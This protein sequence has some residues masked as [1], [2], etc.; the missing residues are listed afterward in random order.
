[1]RMARALLLLLCL[2]AC[3]ESAAA[4]G[5]PIEDNDYAIDLFTGP[6]LSAGRIVGLGGAYSAIATGVDGAQMN[7]A[8]FAERAAYEI[9][10]WEWELTGGVWLGGLFS[11]NDV[12]NNGSEELGASDSI[13]IAGGARLQFARVGLG[14]TAYYQLYDL[15]DGD[16][17]TEVA[18]GTVRFGF[19]Y[20]FARGAL[21][22]GGALRL[23]T[24][25]L[26]DVDT[27]ATTVSFEGVGAELGALFRP[28]GERYRIAAVF[29]SPLESRPTADTDDEA[30]TG[31]VTSPDGIRRANGLILPDHVHVPWEAVLGFAYQF[32][33][34]RT[35]VVWR[36]TDAIK[37]KLKRQIAEG[38]YQPPETFGGPAYPALP[39]DPNAALRTAIEHD[40]EAERRYLSTQPR[41]YLLLSA[42]VLLYGPS[43]AAQSVAAFLTQER[44]PSGEKV[45]L[46]V[47]VGAESEIIDNWLKVRAGSYLEPSRT[48][49]GTYRPHLTAGSDV[50]LGGFWGYEFRGTGTIDLAP[51]YFNWGV[52]VGLWY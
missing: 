39:A 20:A 35:N 19:G 31:V 16:V 18:F 23:V 2:M 52:A 26:S 8:G 9:D 21:V 10:W 49:D 24:F 5:Q 17:A 50:H 46:G 38:T 22:L 51:R 3:A 7:P 34:R 12:D 36:H 42:D 33:P 43:S 28:G 44:E 25:E 6:V 37:A 47:R 27:G 32:G 4:Q 30:M 15:E 40:R 13:A 29:R 48:R 1:M 11:N 45:S 41:R 14:V